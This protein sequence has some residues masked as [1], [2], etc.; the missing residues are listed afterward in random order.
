[1]TCVGFYDNADVLWD[2]PGG[3]AAMGES[4]YHVPI[5]IIPATLVEWLEDSSPDIM[6]ALFERMKLVGLLE[7][8]LNWEFSKAD[9]ML[10]EDETVELYAMDYY[11]KL[12]G[13]LEST[14]PVLLF[15]YIG[16][17]IMLLWAPHAS[18]DIRDAL[19][20]VKKATSGIQ[21]LPPRWKECTNLIN[22]AMME[23]EDLVKRLKEVFKSSL[24]E[25][26][27]MDKETKQKALLKVP[28][29]DPTHAFLKIWHYI[30][31]NNGR[32]KLEKLREPYN[33]DLEWIVGAAVVNAFYDPATNEMVYPTG[34]LQG[35]FYQHGL[36][37][38][39]NFG[40]IGTV[41]GHEMTHG[42]DDTGS[43]FDANGRLEQWWTNETR[44]K[45]DQ[46][47]LC[48]KR[49][50][51]S[52][53]VASLN[54]TVWCNKAREGY[55]REL[56]QYDPHSPN[57]YRASE[58]TSSRRS[59]LFDPLAMD[60]I[61]F[62][63]DGCNST[64]YGPLG[65]PLLLF[66][67]RDPFFRARYGDASRL[68]ED[69]SPSQASN[70]LYQLFEMHALTGPS[71][72]QSLLAGLSP[73]A[74][75]L[76]AQIAAPS[77]SYREHSGVG[78]NA[79]T[80]PSWSRAQRVE[81]VVGEPAR[82][83]DNVAAFTDA[84]WPETHVGD[85]FDGPKPP[86]SAVHAFASRVRPQAL[87][88]AQ[89]LPSCMSCS[90][91]FRS[92]AHVGKQ[93]RAPVTAAP[94]SEQSPL[95]ATVAQ[96]LNVLLEAVR[97]QPCALKGDPES[98]QPS[99][100]SSLRV[101]LPEFSGYSDRISAPKYLEALHHYQ[102]ATRLSDSVMLGSVLPV[103]LPVQAARSSTS[104]P[105]LRHQIPRR[106][107][108]TYVRL[109][110]PSPLTFGAPRYRVLNE[111]AYD[112]KRIQGDI[113]VARAYRPPPPSST[114]LEPHCAWAGRDASHWGSPNHEAAS[115]ARDRDALDVSDRAL[116]PYSYAR[117]A[118]I[119]RQ[120]EQERK[121]RAPVHEGICDRGAPTAASE[122]TPRSSKGL[123]KS[124]PPPV[125]GKGVVCFRCRE[126]GQTVRDMT[127]S[128]PTGGPDP[129]SSD[130]AGTRQHPTTASTVDLP[131]QRQLSPHTEGLPSPAASPQ[132]VESTLPAPATEGTTEPPDNP[133]SDASAAM[134]KEGEEEAN[135]EATLPSVTASKG[136]DANLPQP[137]SKAPTAVD[138][139]RKH[140]SA[141]GSPPDTE[142]FQVVT[143][144]SARRRARDLAAAAALPVDP[145][146]VGTVLFRPS[147]P[148]GTFSGSPRLILAQALST[149]PGVAA[150][151]VNHKRNI[152]AADATTRECLEQ[153]LNIKELK[154]IPVTAK[155][156]A[157]H[158]TSTGFL[159]GVDGEPAVDSLLPGIKSAVPVLS[160]AR[161]GRTVTLRFAGPVPPEHVSL[162][163]VRFPVRPARPRPLQCRQCGRFGHVK[164]SCSWPGSCIRCGRTHP[165]ESCKQTRCVNCG[166]PHSA[167][168]PECPR[169]QEQRKIATIMAS[170]PT[171]LSRRTVAAAVR[172]ENRE[173]RTF[174]SVV[175]GHPAPPL[176]PARPI[177]APRKSRRQPLQG[178]QS[179]SAAAPMALPVAT[180]VPEA[181]P[182]AAAT[183]AAQPAAIAPGGR[184]AVPMA[185]AAPPAATVELPPADPAYQ[186][187]AT[188]LNTLRSVG[189]SLPLDHPLR[190]ICL[191]TGGSPLPTTNHG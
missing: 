123:P 138:T 76:T 121:P 118:T 3:H 190:A 81:D 152:V 159:H 133:P 45:F 66:T 117:A 67:G 134:E 29:L 83:T 128:A 162:F 24:E 68:N 8:L 95:H 158:K 89:T 103:S 175:K 64:G 181:P 109:I 191:Q 21:E 46:K 12:V 9:I 40:A 178:L 90:G 137:F 115:A 31:V 182:A 174:A 163:L 161:E 132:G 169:W 104:L 48:F 141:A 19:F 74:A 27:W 71:P 112:A 167:D 135:Q 75:R 114:S 140:S 156:P 18:R 113:L 93:A 155:E 127:T 120:R 92:D 38:S 96:L 186:I 84:R 106:W 136:T 43:Q 78:G 168:T 150:I 124:P 80:D 4:L 149:R 116:D 52:I 1:M 30:A 180:A 14:N 47:A 154:G 33:K 105:I 119:A 151:R 91:P 28:Q 142:G 26:R 59:F 97:S 157:D 147:A 58:Q 139:T 34:I 98:P 129:T 23:V 79:L 42:F 144:K 110:Q 88:G 57:Q 108:E 17:R 69:H 35:V 73:S 49:Q 184:P 36:P 62:E 176:P 15:N 20:G 44:T 82:L 94:T 122:R 101:P 164:E 5:N 13:F 179:T 54:L 183:P 148:G 173:A 131:P 171:I 86:C 65:D 99:V 172:E 126:R 165:G 143:T 16:L 55:L 51:G 188:L 72:A 177:P 61:S 39:I 53:S 145:A 11:K 185:P 10:T 187:V 70:G 87:V 37:R 60:L 102:Q 85:A 22:D 32:K 77:P 7:D 170:S 41:V 125:G 130:G 166:G 50:Y 56:I 111:L 189:E 100:P 63:A 6:K 25:N 107:S 146:I 153:L 160:A 2:C